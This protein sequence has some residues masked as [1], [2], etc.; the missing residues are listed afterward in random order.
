[1][2]IE[3]TI[4]PAGEFEAQVSGTIVFV[5][6]N[7]DELTGTF[8]GVASSF[9]GSV[10]LEGTIAGGTGRFQDASGSFT[11]LGSNTLI[12]NDGNNFIADIEFPFTELISY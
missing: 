6:A 10:G 7:G 11:V 4:V 9:D 2:T 8:F 5:S 12:F 3:G 1:M